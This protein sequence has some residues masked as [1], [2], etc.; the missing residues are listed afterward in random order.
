MSHIYSRED[1]SAKESQGNKI[2]F[3]NFRTLKYINKIRPAIA[4]PH[5]LMCF[6][7]SFITP[8][9]T[10]I[11]SVDLSIEII[12]DFVDNQNWLNHYSLMT[13]S[14]TISGG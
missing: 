8:F 12:V 9:F 4:Q 10:S 14:K 5:D 13:V 3:S 11:L 2:F 7:I 1:V 6:I